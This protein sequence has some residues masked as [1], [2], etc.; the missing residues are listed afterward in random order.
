MREEVRMKIIAEYLNAVKVL[1]LD[2]HSDARGFFMEIY[3][4]DEMDRL[5]IDFRSVQDN[6]A[7][8]LKRGTLRGLHFQ[9]G[10][11]AQAKLVHC[12]AG[13]F[14]NLTADLRKGSPTYGQAVCI[15]LRAD[16]DLLVYVPKGFAHGVAIIE[17]DTEYTYKVDAP[18]NGDPRY[19]GGLSCFY[20][21][22]QLNWEDLLPDTELILSEK[23]RT[24]LS[25]SPEEADSGIDYK[26]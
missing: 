15:R 11:Y 16:D 18:Y 5:G 24:G 19:S 20:D 23:D 6:R 26:E 21:P 17:D 8:S 9:R 14:Y 22:K 7:Y 2:R 1:S 13:S 3:S 12:T 4:Q 10:E 25:A